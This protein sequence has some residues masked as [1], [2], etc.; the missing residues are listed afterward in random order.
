MTRCLRLLLLIVALLALKVAYE[1]QLIGAQKRV[2]GSRLLFTGPTFLQARN[3]E[4]SMPVFKTRRVAVMKMQDGLYEYIDSKYNQ[5]NASVVSESMTK[6]NGQLGQTA[7][8]HG[9]EIARMANNFATGW[10]QMLNSNRENCHKYTFRAYEQFFSFAET[11]LY[12]LALDQGT[13]ACFIEYNGREVPAG[14]EFEDAQIKYSKRVENY[15]LTHYKIASLYAVAA[16]S[17]L[18]F[19]VYILDEGGYLYKF[20]LPKDA[21]YFTSTDTPTQLGAVDLDRHATAH[22]TLY[23]DSLVVKELNE[24]SDDGVMNGY[25]NMAE[26]YDYSFIEAVTVFSDAIIFARGLNLD[27]PMIEQ[28]GCKEASLPIP[29]EAF[30]KKRAETK[31]IIRA[32]EV[33]MYNGRV[34]MHLAYSRAGRTSF[35][36]S[37]FARYQYCNMDNLESIQHQQID[38]GLANQTDW[39]GTN[40]CLTGDFTHG[41]MPIDIVFMPHCNITVVFYQHMYQVF[42]PDQSLIDSRHNPPMT[43]V[44]WMKITPNAILFHRRRF[45]FFL[46]GNELWISSEVNTCN[47]ATWKFDIVGDVYQSQALFKFEEL[48]KPST[49]R[50]S[51]RKPVYDSYRVK[52]EGAKGKRQ[53]NSSRWSPG[54]EYLPGLP[55]DMLIKPEQTSESNETTPQTTPPPWPA[56]PPMPPHPPAKKSSSASV[57]II[58]I[59]VIIIIG[60]VCGSIYYFCFGDSDEPVRRPKSALRKFKTL[61]GPPAAQQSAPPNAGTFEAQS[62]GVGASPASTMTPTLTVRSGLSQSPASSGASGATAGIGAGPKQPLGAKSIQAS[63]NMT[64]KS[65]R[66]SSPSASLDRKSILKTTKSSG[67]KSPL[68]SKLSSKASK[69]PIER[70][71]SRTSNKS[72]SP[73]ESKSKTKLESAKTLRSPS[74]PKS[75]MSGTKSNPTPKGPS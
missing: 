32:L 6:T 31:L 60:I 21:S 40:A 15:P 59:I 23:L 53:T 20:T 27:V 9:N 37:N 17:T 22:N 55:E 8:W 10:D 35:Q 66:K 49:N 2:T 3:W 72:K 54:L 61:G 48:A 56:P 62:R 12:A 30:K 70:H 28:L 33:Y 47:L 25:D 73:I 39:T 36:V 24:A 46:P 4:A 71:G 5:I 43:I 74:S 41:M 68:G 64:R 69:S 14:R 29:S 52:R 11:N 50:R 63:N 44:N 42:K 19:D 51:D 18:S 7:I 38:T 16:V 34:V 67:A 57:V 75:K 1:G 65:V 26:H 13:I 45:Y 58:V